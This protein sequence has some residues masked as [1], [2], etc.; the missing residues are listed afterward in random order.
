MVYNLLSKQAEIIKI[1]DITE[2]IT[3]L[4]YGPFDNGHIMVGLGNGELLAF[5]Y[6]TLNRLEKIQVFE[7]GE[8]IKHISFDPTHY[9]FVS[10]N[11]GQVASVSFG[12]LRTKYLYV[13]FA[14]E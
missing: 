12:D 14:K 5:D 7:E 11:K 10:N 8:A 1:L 6:L 3:A 2:T 9:I 13:E 4:S